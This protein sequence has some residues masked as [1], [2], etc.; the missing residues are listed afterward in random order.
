MRSKKL[1]NKLDEMEQGDGMLPSIRL[2]GNYRAEIEAALW[3]ETR[4][5]QEL[6]KLI[7]KVTHSSHPDIYV[8][9]KYERT[10]FF[11]GASADPAKNEFSAILKACCQAAA[12]QFEDWEYPE[13]AENPRL[14]M[15]GPSK[16]FAHPD[17]GKIEWILDEEEQPL[18][19]VIV[20]FSITPSRKGFPQA[21]WYAV[22]DPDQID[23]QKF[24][25]R[26]PNDL[27]SQQAEKPPT[28]LQKQVSEEAAKFLED[29]D[30]EDAEPETKTRKRRRRR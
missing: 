10:L 12:L 7:F 29:D 23:E 11:W 6:F 14:A 13:D 19:G 20:D 27:L 16:D 22:E 28:D 5:G 18:A 1:W 4:N 25:E 3:K 17:D 21:R 9:D 26:K 15:K 30:G 2:S 24:R 8:G